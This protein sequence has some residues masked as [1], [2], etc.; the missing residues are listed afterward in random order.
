MTVKTDRN[1]ARSRAQLMRM[2]WFRPVHVKTV[3]AQEIRALLTG[4]KLLL[5][6]LRDVELGIRGLLR[7][8]GLK[9]GRVSKGRYEA[10]F[11]AGS[12]ASDARSGRGGDAPGTGEPASRVRQT[13]SD[14]VGHRAC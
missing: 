13:A 5:S 7:G 8:F 9:V 14:V 12:G 11:R 1:D 3:P 10:R 4:R 2:G 6:K